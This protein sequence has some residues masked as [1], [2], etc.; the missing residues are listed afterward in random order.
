[1]AAYADAVT[2]YAS[3]MG[4]TVK[5]NLLYTANQRNYTTQVNQILASGVNII[6]LAMQSSDLP[7]FLQA[8]VDAGIREPNY[9][10][11]G[12]DTLLTPSITTVNGQVSTAAGIGLQSTLL[13]T[14][15]EASG[16]QYD[17]FNA[18][19][20]SVRLSVAR[21]SIASTNNLFV[22]YVGRY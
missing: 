3:Q 16:P 18:T 17:L 22:A 10:F 8:C 15:Q 4:V 12:S 11:L 20:Y 1:M 19:V 5:A 14:L 6:V 9:L 7:Y 13:A 2:S 21:R